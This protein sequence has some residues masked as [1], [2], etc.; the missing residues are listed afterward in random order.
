MDNET[1][2]RNLENGNMHGFGSI[3]EY[4]RISPFYAYMPGSE[5][6]GGIG[7]C[8]VC[9]DTMQD[10]LARSIG[11]YIMCELLI[12]TNNIIKREGILT[13]VGRSY[14]ILY[15]EDSNT[16]TSCDFYSLKLATCYQPGYRPSSLSIG[17]RNRNT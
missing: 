6:A 9:S 4:E 16:Y 15:N 8:N 2:P 3:P 7:N 1:A 14:F 10:V 17:R 12:G 11:R 5:S 13:E